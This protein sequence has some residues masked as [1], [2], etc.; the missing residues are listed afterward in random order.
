MQITARPDP[1]LA[2]T[3]LR[4]GLR[5]PLLIARVAGWAAIGLAA[6]HEL[7]G[8]GLDIPLLVLG[9]LLA[10]GIPLLLINT[11]TRRALDAGRLTTYEI[12]DGGV[13]LSTAESRHAYAWTAFTRVDN[14][15]GQLVFGRTRAR[16]LP[17]P[18]AGLTPAQIEE[19]LG[20]AAGHGLQIR[21]S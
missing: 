9:V 13:A 1:R 14:L 6:L 20:T 2:A 4:H 16:F 7:T 15:A 3:A 8:N 21:H 11:G 5:R 12:S 17:V 10:V 19:V 18:T